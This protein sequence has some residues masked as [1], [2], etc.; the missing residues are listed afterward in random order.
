MAQLKYSDFQSESSESNNGSAN[1][2]GFFNL[3]NNG[4][5]AIVRILHDTPDSLEM[6]SVHPIYLDGKSRKLNCLRNYGDPIDKCPMC[7]MASKEN[8]FPQRRVFV[9]MLQYSTDEN[10]NVVAKPVIW[11]RP[12]KSTVETLVNYM[13]EYG[14]L[15]DMI[16]K[17]KRIG[18]AGDT[19]TTYQYIVA[20]QQMFPQN[21]Y[22]KDTTAFENYSVLNGLVLNKSYEEVDYFTKFN[23]FPATTQNS[24]AP[25]NNVGN[26]N[27]TTSA[28][29]TNGW[30]DVPDGA[31]EDG[32]PFD[33]APAGWTS[34]VPNAVPN[35][36]PATS[37]NNTTPVM[38]APRT[39]AQ[40]WAAN[41]YSNAVAKPIRSY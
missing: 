38:G 11:E 19:N 6:V 5:E 7:V 23:S 9:H 31:E 18:A 16:F 27:S 10:G 12:A 17:I 25:T 26:V 29:S 15:S 35:A 8:K 36:Q 4:D 2:V 39:P 22:T 14:T 28:A 3:K 30:M 1:R 41:N 37:V 32:L 21:I 40:N 24:N 13:N 20:N 33:S 34:P